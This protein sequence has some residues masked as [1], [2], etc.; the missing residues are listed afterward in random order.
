MKHKINRIDPATPEAQ[1]K[2]ELRGAI[3]EFVEENIILASSTIASHATSLIH[4]D[5]L[6]TFG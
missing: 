2:D 6:L 3:D 5:V 4:D 1:A